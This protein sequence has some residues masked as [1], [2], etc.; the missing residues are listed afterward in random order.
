MNLFETTDTQTEEPVKKTGYSPIYPAC[1]CADNFDAKLPSDEGLKRKRIFCM[2]TG[3]TARTGV[4]VAVEVHS[5]RR[6]NITEILAMFCPFC[7]KAYSD[8]FPTTETE[9]TR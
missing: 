3:R 6:K 9:V 1:E 7:G 8:E 2:K 5:K 4:M